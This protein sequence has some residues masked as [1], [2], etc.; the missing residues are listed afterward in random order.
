MIVY[1]AA[2]VFN[3]TCQTTFILLLNAGKAKCVLN[4]FYFQAQGSILRQV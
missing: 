2:P 4:M 3:T 1:V